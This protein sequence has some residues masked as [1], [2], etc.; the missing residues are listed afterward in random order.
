M[1]RM[2]SLERV[3]LYLILVARRPMS[4][5]GE[6][7]GGTTLGD[8]PTRGSAGGGHVYPTS[9]LEH[10]QSELVTGRHHTH[11][12]TRV[13]TPMTSGSLSYNSAPVGRKIKKHHRQRLCRLACLDNQRQ[14]HET[15]RSPYV[16]TQQC[17]YDT[18]YHKSRGNT[19]S[20]LACVT[21]MLSRRLL[22][23]MTEVEGREG[24]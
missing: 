20:V 8:G 3:G 14:I 1:E 9:G 22:C 13:K 21:V 17:V 12:Y 5:R 24:P 4:N 18:R 16:K 15:V 7:D 11:T 23:V 2:E 10:A 19:A 6:R